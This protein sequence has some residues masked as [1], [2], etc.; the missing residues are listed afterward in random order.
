MKPT[1][2]TNGEKM[3]TLTA[4]SFDLNFNQFAHALLMSLQY[5]CADETFAVCATDSKADLVQRIRKELTEG[6]YSTFEK[7]T[8][9]TDDERDAILDVLR[10]RFKE[11]E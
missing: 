5:E 11:F 9:L 6:G 4:E 8:S 3:V 10:K 7:D 2:R 1:L